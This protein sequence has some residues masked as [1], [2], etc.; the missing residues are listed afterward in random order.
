M[1][2]NLNFYTQV[3]WKETYQE[4]AGDFIE[5]VERLKSLG[6]PSD[7]RLVFGFDS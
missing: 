2:E 4:C 1:G 7:I 3:S 6:G 5:W